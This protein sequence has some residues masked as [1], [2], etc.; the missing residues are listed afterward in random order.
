M[1]PHTLNG[2]GTLRKLHYTTIAQGDEIRLTTVVPCRDTHTGILHKKRSVNKAHVRSQHKLYEDA[3]YNDYSRLHRKRSTCSIEHT[4]L[5]SSSYC[6]GYHVWSPYNWHAVDAAVYY[7]DST[8]ALVMFYQDLSIRI[9]IMRRQN[10]QY[11]AAISHVA[12]KFSIWKAWYYRH[13]ITDAEHYRRRHIRNRIVDQ[14]SSRTL[15]NMIR[16]V[17]KQNDNNDKVS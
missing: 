17:Y 1:I 3:K 2:G 4:A 9:V 16:V 12:T 7:E 5:T 8:T 10:K 13:L 11:K 6:Y 15:M 14:D